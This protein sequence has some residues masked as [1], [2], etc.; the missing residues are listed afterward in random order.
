[1]LRVLNSGTRRIG[2]VALTAGAVLGAGPLVAPAYAAD[3]PKADG[4][5]GVTAASAYL[6]DADKEG[7]EAELWGKDA[8]TQREMA[9]TT[10][11]MTAILVN[12]KDDLDRKITV[13]QEYRDY[14]AEE[15]AS[16]ADLQ[17]G[18]ELTA[19]QVLYGLM[20]PSGCDAAFALADHFGEGDTVKERT[21]DFITQMNER[22]AELGLKGTK[23]DSFD[24]I[25][26]GTNNYSTAADMAKLAAH[27]LTQDAVAETVKATD[28]VQKAT[29]G[30][31]YTWYNTNQ[32]LGSYDGAI[33][34]KTGT[35]TRAGPCLLFAATRDGRT[36]A[37][38]ILN[39]QERYTDAAKMLDWAFDTKSATKLKLR[40]LP[41]GAQRD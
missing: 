4:P 32:L 2:A 3:S 7:E 13:K 28:T 19:R 35:G 6:L 29:N 21:A 39:G 15:G 22:A 37:G 18:D 10:K 33:G 1:M 26:T 9:S 27:A 16:T 41:E 36:V 34:I 5:E 11:I 40:K 14:V 31:T 20:L 8:D 24:G 17:V 38:A 30:R 25:P 23:F 12:E